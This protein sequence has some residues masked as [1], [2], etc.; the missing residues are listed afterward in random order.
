MSGN[1]IGTLFR[2]TTFGESHGDSIG[3]II[4]GC[5]SNVALDFEQIDEDLRRRMPQGKFFTS[6]KE[7]DK[8]EF[9]SGV[10]E[11]KTLG[12]P[13]AFRIQNGNAHSADYDKIKNIYR[14]SHADRVYQEK[15]GIRDYRGGGRSSGRETAAR[16]VAGSIAKQILNAEHISITG[17]VSQIGSITLDK[18]Y[19]QLNL[20][21]A[22]TNEFYCPDKKTL[23]DIFSYSEKVLH[24]KDSVGGVVS[25]VIKGIPMGLGEPVFDRLSADLAKAMLSIG[26]SKGFE[27]GTGFRSAEMKGSEYVDKFEKNYRTTTN[28][29]GGIQGG[30]ST[31]EDVYFSVAF[32]PISSIQQPLPVISDSGELSEVEIGG[33]H[34]V[35]HVPRT[36]PVVESMAALVVLDHLLRYKSYK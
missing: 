15:Y 34:D 32:R 24:S 3:G 17:F 11:G 5:P 20:Q 23:Q 30:I 7:P 14:P 4:D 36:V 1:T 8:V 31:G 16:V 10:F 27:F 6:R 13:I 21:E 29:S 35:C 19:T 2:V 18:D 33:R 22:R 26:S 25:C 12:T 28:H 9:L